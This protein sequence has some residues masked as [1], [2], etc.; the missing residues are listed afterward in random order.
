MA[1]NTP[2]FH[3]RGDSKDA[4]VSQSGKTGI[5]LFS[6]ATTAP[7]VEALVASG[8]FG[9][10]VIN[11]NAT[12]V[13][14]LA[15][16]GMNNWS[17]VP[18]IA[19]LIRF[20][21]LGSS[22][23]PEAFGLWTAS[24]GYI[25]NVTANFF[26][27][28]FNTA[29]KL[30]IAFQDTRG[31]SIVNTV[32]SSI[33]NDWVNGQF[34]D[35]MFSWDGTSGA[36]KFKVSIDGVLFES[37]TA[38]SNAMSAPSRPCAMAILIG[39]MIDAPLSRIKVNE[40]AVWNTAENP[41]YAP[42]SAW[43]AS[44]A[45]DGTLYVVPSDANIR[46]GQAVTRAGVASSGTCAVPAAADTRFGTPVDAT[47]GTCHVPLVAETEHGVAVDVSGVGTYRGYDLWS[48]TPADKISLGYS[49]TQDGSTVIGTDVG[50]AFNSVLTADEIA[51]GLSIMNLNAIV[52]GTY[53]A[54]DRWTALS[55]PDVRA[56]LAYKS[57]S[58]TNNRTGTLDPVSNSIV[59]PDLVFEIDDEPGEAR[60]TQ[61]DQ[62]A[63]AVRLKTGPSTYEDLT[64]ATFSTYLLKSDGTTLTIPNGQHTPDPDQTTNRGR[65]LIDLLAA[66]TGALALGAHR[67]VTKLSQGDDILHFNGVLRVLSASPAVP[68]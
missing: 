12:V 1:F 66:D 32:G 58:T 57:N 53:A 35:V 31:A 20:Q 11:I 8:C 38:A 56:G 9:D 13:R 6:G 29:G 64:G 41:V 14:A 26:E 60:V 2:I 43:I 30:I 16:A 15:Y 3:V 7:V 34:Y 47:T 23:L 37:F 21:Y 5:D 52:V 36:S 4:R 17:Q 51:I 68:I 19:G 45:F 33:K 61:G 62:V 28:G 42:R 18:A 24:V 22:G 63:L 49:T 27:L 39:T 10:S 44:T 54:T 48:S 67:I 55:A 50:T 40:V 65:M 25:S 46:L 59:S